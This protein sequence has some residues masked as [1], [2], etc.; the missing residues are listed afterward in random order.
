AYER[1]LRTLS[2]L[3]EVRLWGSSQVS[4]AKQEGLS[5]PGARSR[6]TAQLAAAIAEQMGV[7]PAEMEHV[8]FAGYLLEVGKIGLHRDLLARRSGM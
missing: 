7:S 3:V 1:T 5:T 8:R 6:Q 4:A 2:G